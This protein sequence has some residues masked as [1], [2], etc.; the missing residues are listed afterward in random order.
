MTFI[1]YEGKPF[2]KSPWSLK[3]SNFLFLFCLA[4][5]ALTWGI[6]PNGNTITASQGK[7][8]Q[9][10]KSIDPLPQARAPRF[11]DGMLWPH[12]ILSLL[13]LPYLMPPFI[14]FSP[15]INY[16]GHHPHPHWITKKINWAFTVSL[17]WYW[18][19]YM[20]SLKPHGKPK[21]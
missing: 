2:P 7:K 17:V 15:L 3:H 13:L 20:H 21:R 10:D 1:W 6:S 9:N 4:L 5:K 12:T 18:I 8:N 11:S 14:S 16:H 19:H